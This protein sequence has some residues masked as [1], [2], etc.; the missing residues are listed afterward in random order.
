M[1]VE[2]V[3]T[4]SIMNYIT[5]TI[6]SSPPNCAAGLLRVL[7]LSWEPSPHVTL[8]VVQALHVLQLPIFKY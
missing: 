4:V 1:V 2:Q 5:W 3:Y 8:Q 6:Q 7:V